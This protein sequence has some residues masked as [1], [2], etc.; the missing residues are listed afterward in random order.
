[1]QHILDHAW[2][3]KREG[4]A[5]STITTRIKL[6]KALARKTNLLEPEDIKSYIALSKVSN[7]RKE[8]QVYAYAKFAD[9]FQLPFKPPRYTRVETLPF[10]PLEREI[11]DL[12]ASVN[13]KTATYLQFIKE[14]G[15]RAGEAWHIKWTQLDL[16]H[17][18]VT[19]LPEKHS[20]PRLLKMSSKLVGM[21]NRLPRIDDYVFGSGDLDNFARW[22]YVKRRQVSV[23][24]NNPR[25]RQISFKT[26]RHFKATMEYHRTKDIL[27]VMQIL[28]H[29]NIR[30]TLVYTHLIDSGSADD[31]YVCKVAKNVEEA[32]GL[33]EAGFEYVTNI[34]SHAIFRKR[35]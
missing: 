13:P 17:A 9:Q 16:E 8:L 23:K 1:M 4:Y 28:G 31:D 5:E 25:L 35:K 27:H 18:T 14:T 12:I 34:D 32:T 10:I 33:I 2:Q 24:L 11:D 22:Y 29:K 21:L 15:A 30:N 3:L 20:R 7:S 19:I 26:L 6:L